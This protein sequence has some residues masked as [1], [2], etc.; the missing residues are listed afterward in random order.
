LV[1]VHIFQFYKVFYFPRYLNKLFLGAAKA[2]W[3]KDQDK[4][5]NIQV[6]CFANKYQHRVSFP[7]ILYHS[8]CQKIIECIDI[9]YFKKNH[10]PTALSQ[11]ET[12]CC[13]RNKCRYHFS[14]PYNKNLVEIKRKKRRLAVHQVHLSH[15]FQFIRN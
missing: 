8:L 11:A 15:S 12:H 10:A 9:R 5:L 1:I 2:L 6:G 7:S 13:I 3:D 14:I 4:T